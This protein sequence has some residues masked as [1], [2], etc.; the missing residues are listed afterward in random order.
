VEVK[1]AR[2][3]TSTVSVIRVLIVARN[4]HHAAVLLD[5]LAARGCAIFFSENC[6]S[7]LRMLN[8]KQ[9]DMVLSELVLPDGAADLFVESLARSRAE[10]FFTH[11]I[12]D[13]ARWFRVLV[14]GKSHWYKTSLVSSEQFFVQL[15]CLLQVRVAH[16]DSGYS[17]GRK[18]QKRSKISIARRIRR[19]SLLLILATAGLTLWL[20][21]GFYEA[22]D[23]HVVPV[24]DPATVVTVVGTVQTVQEHQCSLGWSESG[25]PKIPLTSWLGTR[26]LLR[27]QYG[28]LDV[29]IGPAFYLKEHHFA[30]NKGDRIEVTGSKFARELPVLVIAREIKKGVTYLELRDRAGAP[31]WTNEASGIRK[32]NA[33]GEPSRQGQIAAVRLATNRNEV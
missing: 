23:E 19:S 12:E 6:Q 32:D 21:G 3:G 31:L 9:F 14:G 1:L 17:T 16:P 28:M 8:E 18:R 29:H 25:V 11:T 22:A 10:V 20:F 26:A 24:Y 15:K 2:K 13:G 4:A 27:T 30:L 7:A 33:A 5:W